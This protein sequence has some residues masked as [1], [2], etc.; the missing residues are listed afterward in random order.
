MEFNLQSLKSI[1]F[2]CHEVNCTTA[3][4]VPIKEN[5]SPG[6]SWSWIK[7][8]REIHLDKI[9]KDVLLIL[10]YPLAFQLNYKEVHKSHSRDLRERT[11]TFSSDK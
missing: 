3:A 11:L 5:L 9:L 7:S 4:D 10:I 2:L 6:I 8:P 1:L